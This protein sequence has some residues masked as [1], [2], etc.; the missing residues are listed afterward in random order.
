MSVL[1]VY[2][3]GFEMADNTDG[4]S[5]ITIV[6]EDAPIPMMRWLQFRPD[7]RMFVPG[8]REYVRNSNVLTR[9]ISTPIIAAGFNFS[10]GH[11][12]TN[13]GFDKEFENVFN[14]EE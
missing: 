4:N 1:S 3:H 12:I 8:S 7:N 9:P 14:W 13:A 11:L 5:A 6:G 10:H 2:P